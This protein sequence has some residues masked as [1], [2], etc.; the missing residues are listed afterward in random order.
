M[1]I[2]PVFFRRTFD[3]DKR[4]YG[5]YLGGNEHTEIPVFIKEPNLVM[6][7]VW[8]SEDVVPATALHIRRRI[9]PHLDSIIRAKRMDVEVQWDYLTIRL[10][11][12]EDLF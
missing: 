1:S 4:W 2:H 7:M 9:I 8:E 3:G 6:R 10:M 12:R 11:L 5:G